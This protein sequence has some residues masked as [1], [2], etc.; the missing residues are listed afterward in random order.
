MIY[1][2]NLKLWDIGRHLFLPFGLSVCLSVD[3]S[4]CLPVDLSVDLSICLSVCL[5]KFMIIIWSYINL[6][7]STLKFPFIFLLVSMSKIL[8]Y[9]SITIQLISFCCIPD[10]S[11]SFKCTS[12]ICLFR[13]QPSNTE[14]L[15]FLSF[16]VSKY[17]FDPAN[18]QYIGQDKL[19]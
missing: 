4:V 15:H 10:A 8:E 14:S 7:R 1:F 3:L 16:N 19:I 18:L 11:V 6:K 9:L 5:F 13:F 12:H 17:G 2:L